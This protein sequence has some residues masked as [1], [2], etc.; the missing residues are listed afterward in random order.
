M[1]EAGYQ[2]SRPIQKSIIAAV[3]ENATK[4]YENI[5][6]PRVFIDQLYELK[7]NENFND[8]DIKDEIDTIILAVK[9]K[10]KYFK[11]EITNFLALNSEILG[12]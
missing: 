5:M 7:Q 6:K 4:T 11:Y 10:I 1:A 12:N 8:T 3:K 2:I 9:D